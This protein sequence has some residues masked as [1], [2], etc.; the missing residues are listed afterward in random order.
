MRAE[1][2]GEQ[3]SLSILS[4]G[5]SFY[6]E[7]IQNMIADSNTGTQKRQNLFLLILNIDSEFIVFHVIFFLDK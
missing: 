2:L 4:P 7:D 5:D 6:D 1:E 3:R